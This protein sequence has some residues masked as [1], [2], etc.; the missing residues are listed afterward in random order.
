MLDEN[1]NEDNPFE[2]DYLKKVGEL[3]KARL[4]EMLP[5]KVI[6]DLYMKIYIKNVLAQK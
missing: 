2:K 4:I 3:D 6:E 1:F 5:K